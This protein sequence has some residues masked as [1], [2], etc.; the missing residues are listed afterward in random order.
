MCR[1]V[2]ADLTG[3]RRIPQELSHIIPNFPSVPVQ[4]IILAS[5]REYGML[6]HWR[7]FRRVLPEYPYADSKQLLENFETAVIHPIENWQKE[8]AGAAAFCKSGLRSRN[9]DYQ[10]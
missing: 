7:Q 8:S 10:A 1:F 4:P 9:G 3:A 2:I 6:E 5:Q